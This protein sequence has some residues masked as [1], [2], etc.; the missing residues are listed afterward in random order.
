[1]RGGKQTLVLPS[2]CER[3]NH[4]G[5][6][7]FKQ[8]CIF[9]LG[10]FLSKNK[11][12]RA[13]RSQEGRMQPG[14]EPFPPS[15]SPL[16]EGVKVGSRGP[17]CQSWAQVTAAPYEKSVGIGYSQQIPFFSIAGLNHVGKSFN[18][19]VHFTGKKFSSS[20][21][22][23]CLFAF[24]HLWPTVFFMKLRRFLSGRSR[25]C[26]WSPALPTILGAVTQNN[27]GP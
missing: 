18:T 12:S 22:V 19:H 20:L 7:G 25:M 10:T 3:N 14:W 15:A 1:M 6:H 13:F 21:P 11:G 26:W 4:F 23:I 16:C 5:S 17:W 2:F 9:S 8:K 24:S 27:G